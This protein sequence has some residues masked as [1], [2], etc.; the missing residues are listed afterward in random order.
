[1]KKALPWLGADIFLVI[2]YTITIQWLLSYYPTPQ[3]TWDS[4]YYVKT[5]ITHEHG[6]RPSG[7]AYF[8]DLLYAINPKIWFVASV[9]FSIYLI[10]IIIFLKSIKKTIDLQLSHYLI[11]GAILCT[12]PIALYQNNSVLSDTLFSSCSLIA[13][14]SLLTYLSNLKYRYLI[15]HII[16]V[17]I[18]IEIRHIA[19]FYPFF[20]CF[21]LVIFTKGLRL[22]IISIISILA[23]FFGLY[24][25]HTYQNKEH[26]G[27]SIYSAF[28]GW[29]HTNNTLYGLSQIN[30]DPNTISNTDLRMMHVFFK[31]Y[32]DTSGFK[33]ESIGSGFLWDDKSP[34]NVLR[35]KWA[36]SFKLDYNAS[37]YYAAPYFHYYGMYLQKRFPMVYIKSYIVP[38]TKTLLMPAMGEMEI[39]NMVPYIDTALLHRYKITERAF[40]CDDIYNRDVNGYIKTS[41]RVILRLFICCSIFIAL[42]WKKLGWLKYKKYITL[43]LFTYCFYGLTLYSSWF[44]FRYLLP[45]YPLMLAIILLT[46]TTLL[47]Q[48]LNTTKNDRQSI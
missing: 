22:K 37:W 31:N 34:M 20:T 48:T 15:I 23:I 40:W 25:W 10:A 2:L 1:M 11:L 24:K 16:F 4:F 33:P 30:I 46:F 35:M 3:C 19:L 26:Y 6:I 18:C 41:Y 42:S 29:T 43:I 9:Q 38:N 5:S 45:I 14:S 8:L 13:I 28:S 47:P 36:D 21:I 44:M 17:F 27:V 7:Y 12:E 32:M 39:Y